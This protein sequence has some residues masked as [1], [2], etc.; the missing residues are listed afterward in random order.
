MVVV[1]GVLSSIALPKMS[2]IKA[3]A[4]LSELVVQ[5]SAFEK[6]GGAH[7]ALTGSVPVDLK[8]MG[9]GVPNS[10]YFSYTSMQQGS[11]STSG[12]PNVGKNQG[13]GQVK[14]V[15]CHGGHSITIANPA[16]YNAHLAHGDGV[17]ACESGSPELILKAVLLTPLAPSCAQG[18]SIQSQ[19]GLSGALQVELVGSCMNYMVH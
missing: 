17:G 14:Q 6:L 1:I 8:E 10:V 7:V 9:F 5:F 2:Q 3:K 16:V 11:A 19:L 12:S 13:K 4:V 15:V 18:S